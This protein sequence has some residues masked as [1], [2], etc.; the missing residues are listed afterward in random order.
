MVYVTT[1]DGIADASGAGTVVVDMEVVDVETINFSSL[2]VH[3]IR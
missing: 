3:K 2:L 1:A